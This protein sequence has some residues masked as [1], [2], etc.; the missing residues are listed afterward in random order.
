MLYQPLFVAVFVEHLSAIKKCQKDDWQRHKAKCSRRIV[1]RSK[2]G[3]AHSVEL[4]CTDTVLD[5]R[6]KLET[7]IGFERGRDEVIQF[8]MKEKVLN[9]GKKLMKLFR[10]GD[11][12]E[13]QYEVLSS[14]S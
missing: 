14:V 12:A 1:V 2:T 11:L 13:C 8:V 5:M 3:V 7:E 6:Y 4:R 10:I 9:E